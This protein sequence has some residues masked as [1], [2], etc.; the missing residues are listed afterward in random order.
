[1]AKYSNYKSNLAILAKAPEQDL[2]NEFV[3]SG[4]INKF[5]LQFELAWKL[6]R[7]AL[8]HEGRQDAATR[9][10]RGVIKVAYTA[11]DFID[12]G[13]W[14]SMLEDR[15]AA[16]HVYD[17]CLAIRLVDDILARYISEFENL[18]AILESMYGK[19]LLETF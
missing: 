15:N 18:I 7:E 16:E 10:P 13:L 6:M 3:Q 4:I 2:T 17:S 19:D 14:L 12:E 11:Y 9:S 5:S 1:M 8:R